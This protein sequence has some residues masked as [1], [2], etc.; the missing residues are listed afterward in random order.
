MILIQIIAFHLS[1]WSDGRKEFFLLLF[2]LFGL[3]IGVFFGRGVFFLTFGLHI[4]ISFGRSCCFGLII[5]SR[6]F[7]VS[8]F[9]DIARQC[10]D[11]AM[12]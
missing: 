9:F 6:V 7:F 11:I 1:F 2:F 3:I 8:Y 5:G 10:F 4:G 12:P